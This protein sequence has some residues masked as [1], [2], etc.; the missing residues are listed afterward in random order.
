VTKQQLACPSGLMTTVGDLSFTKSKYLTLVLNQN[1]F[2]TKLKWKL[3]VALKFGFELGL[4]LRP[5]VKT[6]VKK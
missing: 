6:K 4:N 1:L 2:I 5:S 3:K